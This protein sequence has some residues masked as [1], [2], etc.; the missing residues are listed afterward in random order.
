MRKVGRRRSFE[1]ALLA[2]RIPAFDLLERVADVPAEDDRA[3]SVSTT[4]I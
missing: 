3:S 4:T 2:R 1:H